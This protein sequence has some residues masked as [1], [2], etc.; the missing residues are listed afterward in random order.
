MT[1]ETIITDALIAARLLRPYYGRAIAALTPVAA[2]G[3][4][5][6]GVDKWWRLY[7]DPE[8]LAAQ[9]LPHRAAL[10]GAH[11]VEHLLRRH[12]RRRG[13][14]DP[15]LWNI[16]GDCEINDD[17][18]EADLPANHV[19]PCKCGCKDG[20]LAEEYYDHVESKATKV[21]V[22]GCGSGAGGAPLPCEVGGEGNGKDVTPG[23]TDAARDALVQA[24]A[25]D[26]RDH[27]AKHPGTVPAEVEMWANAVAEPVRVPWPRQLA[28]RLATLRTLLARGRDDYAWSKLG[29]RARPGVP[30]RPGTVRMVPEVAL[31]V[32]TSGSMAAE[33]KRVLGVVEDLM[34]RSGLTLAETIECDAKVQARGKGKRRVKGAGGGGTDL[35]VALNGLKRAA[36]VVTDGYTPW[37][38][39]AP[40][41][42]VVV[43][44]INEEP[45][46]AVP[47]WATLVCAWPE[48][49]AK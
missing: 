14:R 21:T 33:G 18:P 25:A 11:E 24:V 22:P 2:P 43:V 27:A 30:L 15:R 40:A 47:P 20:L 44:L 34:R 5:T 46:D 39:A 12:E 35:R 41:R 45:Q 28:G 8:W 3:L 9:T 10:I 48:K 32:D 36:V 29:R 4:G 17:V 38:E 19:R 26:V 49:G 7:Y 42:P 37:P 23:M 31:V 6:V 1:D 13:C 16:A